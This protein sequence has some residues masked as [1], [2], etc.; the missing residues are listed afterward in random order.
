MKEFW[1]NRYANEDYSYGIEPNEF[2][3]AKLSGLSPGK[4][5]LPGDGEGRNSFYAL[6]LGWDVTAVDYS[7]EGKNKATKLANSNGFD[8]NYQIADL[9]D[10]KTPSNNY[11]CIAF[12]YIHLPPDTRKIV[13]KNSI[14]WLKKGGTLVLEAF[15]KDQLKY[16]TGGPKNIEM[17]FSIEELKSDFADLSILLLEQKEVHLSEGKGHDGMAS[18]IRMV[19]T[20]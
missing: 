1:N 14:S 4:L 15:S 13:H 12:T 17:L 8:L 20:K 3:K 6:K 10:F 2:F 5:L 7:I 18:V 19:A 16:N 11:D 9:K